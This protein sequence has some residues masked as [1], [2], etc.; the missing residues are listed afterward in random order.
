MSAE[1]QALRARKEMLRQE[2]QAE[3]QKEKA[4]QEDIDVLKEKI[5][6]HSI[7]KELNAK[8]ESIKQLESK[9]S[10]LQGQL[11]EPAKDTGKDA[12]LP[13]DRKKL[14]NIDE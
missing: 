13:I 2:L 10:E 12:S 6:I 7:E 1:I 8:R 9:K 14:F 11:N 5:E 4:L 3:E